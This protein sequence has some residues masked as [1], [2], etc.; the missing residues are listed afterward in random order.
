MTIDNREYIKYL[1][2]TLIYSRKTPRNPIDYDSDHDHN[3]D[4]DLDL[5]LDHKLALVGTN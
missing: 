4:Y 3:H 1:P 2:K 5:D